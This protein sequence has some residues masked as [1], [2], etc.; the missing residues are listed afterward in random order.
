[1]KQTKLIMGMPI[2]IEI[3]DEEVTTKIFEEIFTYFRTIDEKFSPYRKTSEVSLINK[4]KLTNSEMSFEMRK[5]LELAGQTKLAT[6][7]YF[8]VYHKGIFDPSGIVKGWAI[9]KAAEI[10]K[11]KGFR[12]FFIDAGGDIQVS[13]Y[14]KQERLWKVGIRNPF[15]R[16]ENV[17]VLALNGQGVATSGT[18]VRGNHIY[19]P[20]ES[21]F[22]LK[23]IVS[24]TVIGPN[25]YEADR[26]ATAAFAMDKKGIYF[27]E[28]L[29]EF[30]GYMIDQNGSAI[31]T[32]GFEKY[33][34]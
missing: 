2:T 17:R 3:V 19:N 8:D 34:I 1:M 22:L 10:L 29:P 31:Y 21:D 27:I 23:N 9:K 33:C 26:F 25:V 5:I 12:N 14:N 30:E 4:N 24:L 16:F 6:N 28:S 15:N 18:A 7:G 13:G 11:E 20:H 32:T